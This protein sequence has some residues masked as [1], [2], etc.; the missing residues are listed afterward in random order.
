MGAQFLLAL[1]AAA[2]IGIAGMARIGIA[3]TRRAESR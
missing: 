3:G 1:L 2:V